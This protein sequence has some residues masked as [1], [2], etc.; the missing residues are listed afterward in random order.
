M[1]GNFQMFALAG[2]IIGPSGVDMSGAMHDVEFYSIDPNAYILGDH[3][4]WKVNKGRVLQMSGVLRGSGS[5]TKEG[6]GILRLGGPGP[7]PNAIDGPMVIKAGEVDCTTGG[8][9][10]L[11]S[12]GKLTL[13]G[14]SLNIGFMKNAVVG[15]VTIAAAASQ[16]D[17]ITAV[18]GELRGKSYTATLTSGNAVV[19]APLM[20]PGVLKM[21]GAGGTLTLTC[22]NGY[23]GDTV[24]EAGTLALQG[25]GKAS[26]SASIQ[27]A[28]GAA[29]DLA[30]ADSLAFQEHQTLAAISASGQARIHAPSKT[31]SVHAKSKLAFRAGGD[32]GTVGRILVTGNVDLNKNVVTMHVSGS[33]LRV[34]TYRLLEC[35]GTL[36]GVA[37]SSP[38]LTGNGLEGGQSAT[39]QTTAGDGGYVELVVT[40][41]RKH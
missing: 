23:G 39:I 34:G 26:Q 11:L 16:G 29:L 6:E 30:G 12:N 1:T 15:D 27:I 33:R 21:S 41:A 3:Q 22:E 7:L 13:Q 18:Q 32:H 4:T 20:G 40:E 28:S 31:V 25:R 24:I 37:D 8:N 5:L 10:S 17:T 9:K 19:S 36:S 38:I 35:T 2:I 14:G